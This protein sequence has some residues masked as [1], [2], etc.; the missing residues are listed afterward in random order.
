MT[1][2]R[3]SHSVFSEHT[4]FRLKKTCCFKSCFK[5]KEIGAIYSSRTYNDIILEYVCVPRPCFVLVTVVRCHGEQRKQAIDYAI[6]NRSLAIRLTYC[7]LSTM[8]KNTNDTQSSLGRQTIEY[9]RWL[10]PFIRSYCVATVNLFSE[11]CTRD[12]NLPLRCR[13]ATRK[14]TPKGQHVSTCVYEYY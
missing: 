12:N 10:H 5:A 8:F 3:L 1:D 7:F 9:I 4:A 6:P 14:V 2:Y 11:Q 13:S